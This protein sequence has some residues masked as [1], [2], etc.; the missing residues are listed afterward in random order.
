MVVVYFLPDIQHRAV[1]HSSISKQFFR[2][3]S[4]FFLNKKPLL[5]ILVLQIPLYSLPKII[6]FFEFYFLPFTILF[7]T[8]FFLCGVPL[9][10]TKFS[11]RLDFGHFEHHPFDKLPKRMH[12]LGLEWF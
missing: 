12:V 1:I 11:P 10:L 6:A 9:I 2:L 3:G 4:G 5:S 7:H 8:L